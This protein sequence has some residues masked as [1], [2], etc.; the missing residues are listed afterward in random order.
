M[1]LGQNSSL[2]IPEFLFPK[3]NKNK[4]N[5]IISL[6]N[7]SAWLAEQAE[8]MG[9]EVLPGIAGD[10]PLFNEDGSVAGVIT[11]DMGIAK[12]GT[13]KDTY[14]P[15]IEIKAK[16]TIFAEGCRGSITEHLKKHFHLERESV[17]I[18]HYGFGLKEIW[19]V[20]NKHFEPGLA[21]HTVG[22]PLTTDV[23][24]GSFLYHM[25]PN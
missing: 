15:G 1:I 23:Y 3:A 11:G 21:M 5:Y 22:W 16:Q 24:G 2:N 20:D 17:S 14:Q 19:Q 13:L 4:G 6:G 9:V 8:E 25:N 18:Q 10:K 7:L 12:D